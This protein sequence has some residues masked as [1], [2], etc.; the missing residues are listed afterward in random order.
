MLKYKY[1][2]ILNSFNLKHLNFVALRDIPGGSVVKTPYASTCRGNIDPLSR[3]TKVLHGARNGKNK[4]TKPIKSG[5]L[6]VTTNIVSMEQMVNS[7]IT[8]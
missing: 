3:G 1:Y 4:Q 5:H 8:L 7:I 2:R 6:L